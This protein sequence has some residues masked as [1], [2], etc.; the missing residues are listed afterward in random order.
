MFVARLALAEEKSFAPSSP[1]KDTIPE[2][3]KITVTES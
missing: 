2:P 1:V 3:R